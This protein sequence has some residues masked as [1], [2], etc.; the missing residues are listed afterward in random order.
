MT[1]PLSTK[2][3]RLHTNKKFD[4]II[5]S[6]TKQSTSIPEDERLLSDKYRE[7]EYVYKERR[8]QTECKQLIISKSGLE[9]T[10]V[11]L[12][13]K[14]IALRTGASRLETNSA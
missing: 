2:Y 9:I 8:A 5:F 3:D 6:R 4:D 13:V 1:S 10:K 14:S 7:N 12:I 11:L